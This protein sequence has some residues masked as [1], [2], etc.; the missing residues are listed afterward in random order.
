MKH[1]K[2][3]S[4]MT[5][6]LTADNEQHFKDLAELVEV[7]NSLSAKIMIMSAVIVCY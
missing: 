1:Y 7:R 5:G 2:V 6:R 3:W 4:D